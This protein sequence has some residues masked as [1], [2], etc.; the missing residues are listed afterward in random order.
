MTPRLSIVIPVYNEEGNIVELYRRLLAVVENLKTSFEIIFVDD[1]SADGSD[2]LLQDLHGSD[3]R[4]K[5][6]RLSRNF[7]HQMALTAGIDFADGDAVITMDGDLQ[8]PPEVIPSLVK[9]WEEGN[10]IVYTIRRDTKKITLFKR[11]S[12]RLFY[13]LINLLSQTTI[14][15]NTSDFRLMDRKVVKVFR[16]LRE[17]QRFL[18]GLVFWVG[19]KRRAV[20][21]VADERHAGHEK[22]SLPKMVAF[23]LDSIIAFSSFPLVLA[24][25]IGCAISVLSF[26][27]G[28][29]IFYVKVVHGTTLLPGIASVLI[30]VTF[31][32]GIILISI[33]LL[34]LYLAKVYDEIKRRPLYVIADEI[35]FPG[36]DDEI[37]DN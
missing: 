9:A 29:Y 4:V 19:F 31:M 1:G 24:I 37:L 12:S 35:G 13:V 21:F 18:R 8:H 5:V 27:F 17:R 30:S 23:A 34:G 15:P 22:Y 11:I 36:K 20:T 28:F 16:R 6:L 32:S 26:L 2:A 3:P 10:L 25:F 33:G 7:G 14:E